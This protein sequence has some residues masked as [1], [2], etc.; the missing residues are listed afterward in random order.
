MSTDPAEA[1]PALH[2]GETGCT[3]AEYHNRRRG[4]GCAVFRGRVSGY[5]RT[6]PHGPENG[7]E[8]SFFIDSGGKNNYNTNV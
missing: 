8:L 4:F 6:R 1:F 7:R 3:A 5:V 2:T